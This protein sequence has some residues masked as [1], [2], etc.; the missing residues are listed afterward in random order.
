MTDDE[1]R[2]TKLTPKRGGPR[3]VRR[4]PQRHAARGHEG[5]ARAAGRAPEA[6]VREPRQRRA[7]AGRRA[8]RRAE[9]TAAA[10]TNERLASPRRTR[11]AG[12]IRGQPNGVIR[13]VSS[14]RVESWSR[15][16]LAAY[17]CALPRGFCGGSSPTRPQGSHIP[18]PA[19]Q[20][21]PADGADQLRR[22][23]CADRLHACA[24]RYCSTTP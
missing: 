10:T 12:G 14:C 21:R 2:G 7:A 11:V 15:R 22:H 20:P 19:P 6:T 8:R 1:M 18:D 13:E 4:A 5:R 9:S 23:P 24:A 16:R 17:G 3:R